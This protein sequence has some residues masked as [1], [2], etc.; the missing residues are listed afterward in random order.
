MPDAAAAEIRHLLSYVKLLIIWIFILTLG[1][2]HPIPP[3]V[4]GGGLNVLV[5]LLYYSSALALSLI[6]TKQCK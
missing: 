3:L 1:K 5:L 6:L 2:P 4:K